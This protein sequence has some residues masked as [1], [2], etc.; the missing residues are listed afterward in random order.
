MGRLQ[1]GLECIFLWRNH[2]TENPCHTTLETWYHTYEWVSICSTCITPWVIK[3]PSTRWDPGSYLTIE[4][5][6]PSDN[7]WKQDGP[8]GGCSPLIFVCECA[9]QRL[10]TTVYSNEILV[11]TGASLLH[12]HITFVYWSAPAQDGFHILVQNGVPTYIKLRTH[13]AP[14]HCWPLN[15]LNLW[16]I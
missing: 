1:F 12:T 8:A 15:N 11:R 3:K 9:A 14:R 13:P 7:S 2:T 6:S 5:L 10:L 4:G 16:V